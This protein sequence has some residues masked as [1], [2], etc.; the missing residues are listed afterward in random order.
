MSLTLQPWFLDRHFATD[1]KMAVSRNTELGEK[2]GA[3]LI[4]NILVI[5]FVQVRGSIRLRSEP[6]YE[7]VQ[8]ERVKLQIFILFFKSVCHFG[9]K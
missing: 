9:Q 7:T 6:E 3:R 1:C 8:I 2:S 5:L 4:P